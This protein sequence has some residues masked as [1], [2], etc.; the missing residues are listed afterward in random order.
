ATGGPRVEATEDKVAEIDKIIREIVPADD[1][2]M[3]LANIGISARWSAIYT[4]NN[5]P[6]SAFIRVQLRSGFDGR[7][8]PTLAYV[9]QLRRRWQQRFPADD[10]FFETG[11]L[12]RRILTGGAVAPIEVQIHGRDMNSRR[13]VARAL[14]W[15]INRIPQVKETSLPQSM[16]LPQLK[17][18]A[19]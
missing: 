8:T 7:S 6:H 1:L 10:L 13:A 14:D 19:D 11:G 9:E 2:D 18:N 3:T 5:G 17:I 4:P 16:D 12:I 15:R